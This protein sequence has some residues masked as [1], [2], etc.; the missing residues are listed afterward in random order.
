MTAKKQNTVAFARLRAREKHERCALEEEALVGDVSNQSRD[1]VD[2]FIVMP[3]VDQKG[4]GR[5]AG[6][7]IVGKPQVHLSHRVG[8]K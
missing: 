2:W 4:R 1:G 8:A 5:D 7:P 6:R 3:V